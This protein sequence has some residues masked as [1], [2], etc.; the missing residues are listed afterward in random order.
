MNHRSVSAIWNHGFPGTVNAL[1]LA[2]QP[3]L[4]QCIS[5]YDR[6]LLSCPRLPDQDVVEDKNLLFGMFPF[7]SQ[8]TFSASI[9][10][11]STRPQGRP[12][13]QTWHQLT[14]L[15]IHACPCPF[16][17]AVLC[18]GNFCLR[19][20]SREI[21]QAFRILQEQGHASPDIEIRASMGSHQ[22]NICHCGQR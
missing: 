1:F 18:P 17:F 21:D 5:A 6:P 3:L 10:A 11:D 14:F 9:G 4:Y 19:T 20:D 13:R 7:N 8:G 12:D 15:L 2:K 16:L 22:R